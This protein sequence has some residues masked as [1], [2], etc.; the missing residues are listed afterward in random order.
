MYNMY[1]QSANHGE[2]KCYGLVFSKTD[3][4]SGGEQGPFENNSVHFLPIGAM[5]NCAY[6]WR[7]PAR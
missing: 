5:T 6:L 4:S 7:Y 1:T 3:S 2:G